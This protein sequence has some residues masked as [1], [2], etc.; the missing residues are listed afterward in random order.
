MDPYLE[1]PARW[2]DVHQRLI[3]YIADDLQPQLRPR[4]HARMGERTYILSPPRSFYPDVLLTGHIIRERALVDVAVQTPLAVAEDEPEELG[5]PFIL[6]LLPAEYREPFIEI[7][8]VAGDEVVT[9]I[10]VLSPSN[11]RSGKGQRLYHRKQQEVLDSSAHLVE[12]DLLSE[13]KFTVAIGEE[14]RGLLPPYRYLVSVNRAPERYRFETY[15]IPL[16]R[17]LPPVNVPLREPDPDVTFDLQAVFAR[18]YDNGAYADLVDYGRPPPAHLSSKEAAWAD[19][20]LR[21]KGL[22]DGDGG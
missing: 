9:V 18:C 10:E 17:C 1:D 15:P 12:I 13:G 14:G 22:R 20:L 5:M 11:K 21:G 16:A 7:V 3:T 8:H 19:D 6:N 2:S 4:Y